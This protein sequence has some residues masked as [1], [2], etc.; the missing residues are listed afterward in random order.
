MPD[1]RLMLR[2]G[3][4]SSEC[5]L[6]GCAHTCSGE[7]RARGGTQSD[8]VATHLAGLSPGGLAS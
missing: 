2:S 5:T 4:T 6:W 7:S 8:S 1:G 3:R